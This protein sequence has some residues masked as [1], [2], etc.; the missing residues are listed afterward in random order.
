VRAEKRIS[1]PCYTTADKLWARSSM[2]MPSCLTHMCL[3]LGF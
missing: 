2:L 3:S 1:C